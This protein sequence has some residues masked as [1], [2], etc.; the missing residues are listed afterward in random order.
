MRKGFNAKYVGETGLRK[1]EQVLYSQH[2]SRPFIVK[3]A[4]A[5][6]LLLKHTAKPEQEI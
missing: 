3:K 1:G 6:F 4:Q 5:L 2:F